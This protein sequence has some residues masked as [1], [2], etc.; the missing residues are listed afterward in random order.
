MSGQQREEFEHGATFATSGQLAVVVTEER[1]HLRIYEKA[2]SA[3]QNIAWT[4]FG[5]RHLQYARAELWH[6]EMSYDYQS[7]Y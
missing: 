3:A 7:V 1:I 5:I 2:R 6:N 4:T